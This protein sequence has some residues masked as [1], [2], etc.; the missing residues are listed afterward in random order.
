MDITVIPGKL[1]GTVR[2]IPSKSQAHRMLIC[3]AFSDARTV[4]TCPETNRDIDATVRCLNALGAD[5]TRTSD[6][7]L[8]EPARE[9]PKE[10][11]LPCQ[12]SGSTLR[13]LLPV[14]GALGC[15]ATFRLTGRL[16]QR[17]L[18]PLW[19]EMER[20]GCTLSRPTA[21][22]V[23]CQGRLSPGEYRID[24]GV[25]SQF[26]TGLLLALA[27]VPG[28]SSLMVLGKLE[29]APYVTMTQRAMSL[30]GRNTENFR[31]FGGTFRSPGELTVEGDWS[32]AAFFLAAQALGSDVTVENLNFDSPQGDR[33]CA[34]LL[35]G[36]TEGRLTVDA[37]D[38]PDLVPILAVTAANCHGAVFTNIQRLRLKESDRVETVI[39]LL[40]A[41]GGRAEAASDTLTVWGTGLTGGTVDSRND[42][43]IAMAAAI[44]AT[45][46]SSPVTVLGAQCVEK[47]YPAFWREYQQLGGKYE[48]HLR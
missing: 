38:I 14:A 45:V 10:A 11:E 46:C 6:G 44:G 16:P 7:F 2:A 37:S 20:M 22:T 48:Q 42:H 32:N 12:D 36:L 24:G 13:F 30:F 5:I 40:T 9:I 4:L 19:E 8:V 23:R 47:S 25:S 28:E 43:R 27:L 17:P 39:A 34:A 21:D 35:P 1:H 29:S 26:L 15:E 33:A 18:S 31:I 3:A 41:L